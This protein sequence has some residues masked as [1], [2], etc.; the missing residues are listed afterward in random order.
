[1]GMTGARDPDTDAAESDFI[2]NNYRMAPDSEQ[3]RLR[4]YLVQLKTS[5]AQELAT[6]R[7]Q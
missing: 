3:K 4:A 5:P 1:M 6:R 2:I 7:A